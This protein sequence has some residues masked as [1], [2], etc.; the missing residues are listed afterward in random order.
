MQ[1]MADQQTA[2]GLSGHSLQHSDCWKI[3]MIRSVHPLTIKC[4]WRIISNAN[5]T[6]RNSPGLIIRLCNS[7]SGRDP[8]ALTTVTILPSCSWE[9]V[10]YASA[11]DF[12]G[13][14]HVNLFT[15]NIPNAHWEYLCWLRQ[16]V[17]IKVVFPNSICSS[18]Q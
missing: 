10:I 4:G 14:H 15:V 8:R 16:Y 9:R 5:S 13:F 1:I 7:R 2:T 12:S 6:L 11:I 18:S 3:E 17:E